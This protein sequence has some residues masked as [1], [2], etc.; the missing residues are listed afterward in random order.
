M[1]RDRFL[2]R[3]REAARRGTAYQVHIPALRDDLG[4]V[5]VEGDLCERFAEE[6]NLVGGF[7]KIVGGW[8]EARQ[9]L[10]QLLDEHRCRSALCWRHEVLDKLDLRSLLNDRDVLRWDHESLTLLEPEERRFRALNADIGITSAD[11]AIAETGTLMVC[12]RAGQERSSSLLPPL[13]VAIITADQIVPDLLDAMPRL[14]QPL[15]SSTVLITGPSKT[16]D[17]ELQLTTGVHGPG[18][19][20]VIV[21]DADD[22]NKRD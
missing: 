6:V 8:V 9:H 5:G 14:P 17:I 21:V 13:H 12:S 10:G 1:D 15:P 2:N 18:K 22:D 11:V 7:A 19:V 3:V 16:G 4:Y 20:H